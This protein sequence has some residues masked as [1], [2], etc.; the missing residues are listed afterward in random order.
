MISDSTLAEVHWRYDLRPRTTP[1]RPNESHNQ[2]KKALLPNPTD[3]S[4][5]K[6]ADIPTS[7]A[8]APQKKSKHESKKVPNAN[9]KEAEKTIAPFNIEHEF[10]KIK[11]SVPLGELVQNPAYQNE[12]NKFLKGSKGETH[13]DTLNIQEERPVVMFGPYIEN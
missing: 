4:I 5:A 10:N 1:T 2:K 12:I 7:S 8:I 11:I 13:P 3:K 9:L 6:A